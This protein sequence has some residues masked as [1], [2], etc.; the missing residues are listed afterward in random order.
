MDLDNVALQ[1]VMEPALLTG[2]PEEGSPAS[3]SPEA[4]PSEEVYLPPG[5]E[6]LPDTDDLLTDLYPRHQV[7]AFCYLAN[8]GEH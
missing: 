1:A 8:S 5:Q 3:S 7:K 6:E 2:G 4:P